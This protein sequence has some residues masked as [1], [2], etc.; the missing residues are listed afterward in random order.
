MDQD[1]FDGVG[2]ILG[3]ILGDDDPPYDDADYGDNDNEIDLVG[4]L[5]EDLTDNVG[6]FFGSLYKKVKKAVKSKLL[7]KL[8]IGSAIMFPVGG[9]GIAG[10]L[11]LADRV[12]SV[13]EG[14]A[15]KKARKQVRAALKRTKMLAQ[16]GDHQAKRT[17]NTIVE[18]AKL[19]KAMRAAGPHVR[20]VL[21]TQ[22]GKLLRGTWQRV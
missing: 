2:D 21:A 14:H 6:G 3:D 9:L 7:K 5:D 1:V 13:N 4:A 12:L 11:A 20:G 19:Q 22:D 17:L 16:K 18:A 10:G 15:G 8:A